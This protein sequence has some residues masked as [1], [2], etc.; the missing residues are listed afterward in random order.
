[1]V[2]KGEGKGKGSIEVEVATE[3]AAAD[4]SMAVEITK[5]TGLMDRDD[6]GDKRVCRTG[7]HVNGHGV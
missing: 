1:M 6:G 5:E 3:V 7:D 2:G 4:G